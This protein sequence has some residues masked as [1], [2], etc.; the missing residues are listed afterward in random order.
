M[1]HLKENWQHLTDTKV[2]LKLIGEKLNIAR[3]SLCD[4]DRNNDSNRLQIGPFKNTTG[5]RPVS[6]LADLSMG[7]APGLVVVVKGSRAP[8]VGSPDRSVD[9]GSVQHLSHPMAEC[10]AETLLKGCK[11]KI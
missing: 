3:L 5:L 11:N 9:A 1:K 6:Q 2:N 8:G 7:E 10:P 4:S